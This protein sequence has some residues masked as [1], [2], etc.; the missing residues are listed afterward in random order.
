MKSYSFTDVNKTPG[1]ILD[2]AMQHPVALTKHG[3]ERLVILSAE[4]YH[5]LVGKSVRAAY[6]IHDPSAPHAEELL[7]AI[8]VTL[9]DL[10]KNDRR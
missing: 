5:R 8:D 2:E 6:S 3:K 1:E 9:A 4:R 10:G 7:E